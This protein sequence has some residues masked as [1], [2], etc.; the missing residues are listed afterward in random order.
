MSLDEPPGLPVW[1]W[2]VLAVCALAL[3][4]VVIL[5]GLDAYDVSL[6]RSVLGTSILSSPP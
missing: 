6:L 2:A 1:A 5:L 3:A 4:A